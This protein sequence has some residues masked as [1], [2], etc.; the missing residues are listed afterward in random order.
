MNDDE[1]LLTLIRAIA[2]GDHVAATKALRARPELAAASLGEGA[3]RQRP[4]DFFLDEI[5]HHVYRGDTALHAAAAAHEATI[6]RQ[7][8]ESGATVHATNRR[9]AQP[10]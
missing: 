9:G 3:T 2:R 4:V 5:K 8:I 7:L 1:P 10:L 6:A